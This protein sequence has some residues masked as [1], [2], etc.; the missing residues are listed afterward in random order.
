[1]FR[2]LAHVC[3]FLEENTDENEKWKDETG[4]ESFDRGDRLCLEAAV[5]EYAFFG[6]KDGRGEKDTEDE[7]G[8]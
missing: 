8:K 4:Q 2:K 3:L 6:V 5:N 7:S 1:M